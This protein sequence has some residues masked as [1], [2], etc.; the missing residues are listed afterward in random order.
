VDA[1]SADGSGE[2]CDCYAARDV[3]VRVIH[4]KNA[5][6]SAARNAGVAAAKGDFIGFTD[7]DDIIEAD[8]Y[9]VMM[10]LQEAYG[11]DVVQ[12][13]H[14]RADCINGNPRAAEM[15]FLDGEGF[16]WRMFTKTGGDYTNQV[17][18][19]SK[20][21]RRELFEG[22]TFP[23][24]RVYEDEQETYKLC[25]KAGKIVETPDILYHYI[26]RE[27]SIIT[28]ISARKMLKNPEHLLD[29]QAYFGFEAGEY[30]A[31]GLGF[32][33]EP[34]A[35]ILRELMDDYADIPFILPDGSYDLESCPVRNTRVLVRHGLR[36]DDTRQVL[37]GDILI[38]PSVYLCPMRFW[39]G[40]GQITEE[41]V[42][43][44]WYSASWQSEEERKQHAR[45]ARSA[46][47]AKRKEFLAHIPNHFVMAVL[48]KKGYE[49]LKRTLKK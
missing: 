10:K 23:V 29:H 41:T 12:C 7:S 14:D 18:L 45:Q 25:L 5:G 40:V 3:R 24:G 33:A 17:A 44:H 2:I 28:G 11:A 47:W 37:P 48:G 42:S 16:V 31:T 19:W 8:M 38:L 1:G 46:K 22:I 34:N 13:Q 9:A 26:K 49:K 39:S 21:Y 20:V 6:V 43:V 30:I 35:P 32:G 15:T 36:Q 4:Q 27:N